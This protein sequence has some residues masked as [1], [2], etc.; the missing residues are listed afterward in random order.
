MMDD[1][2]EYGIDKE[3]IIALEAELPSLTFRSIVSRLD[4]VFNKGW[5]YRYNGPVIVDVPKQIPK[6]PQ[7][8]NPRAFITKDMPMWQCA[9]SIEVCLPNG[10]MSI[11]REYCVLVPV[12]E[13]N[14]EL[15]RDLSFMY[16]AYYGWGV[17]KK[18]VEVFKPEMET[19]PSI[20]FEEA[21]D[22][23]KETVRELELVKR[24]LK[25]TKNS[26]LDTYV[27]DW[28]EEFRSHRD[29]NRTNLR[30][31]VTYLK[32]RVNDDEQ[33]LHES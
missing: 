8:K 2:E 26:E 16:A 10:I 11:D 14:F 30:A 20:Q 29:I 23:F 4:E 19:A 24:M 21:P 27:R 5:S 1:T 22:Q 3:K 17:G 6:N 33:L 25:I 7:A 13:G 31:F 15:A 32:T 12:E 9:C 18:T 28:N